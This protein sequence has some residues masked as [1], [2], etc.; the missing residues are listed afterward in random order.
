MR[1]FKQQLDAVTCGTLKTWLEANPEKSFNLFFRRGITASFIKWNDDFCEVV[2][3][4]WCEQ[5]ALCF[6]NPEY[7]EGDKTAVPH[8]TPM[9]ALCSF[10]EIEDRMKAAEEYARQ[11]SHTFPPNERPS[12]AYKVFEYLYLSKGGH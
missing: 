10:D 5:K 3:H 7:K 12:E 4:K 6:R 9:S 1:T 8:L 11:Y 2:F